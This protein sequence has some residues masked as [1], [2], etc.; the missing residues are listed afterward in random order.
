MENKSFLE[1]IKI[2][3]EE[4]RILKLQKE[5]KSGK[6]SKEDLTDEDYEKLITLYEKQNK[7]LKEKIDVQKEKIRKKLKDLKNN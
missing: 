1:N 2:D 3:K 5:Y 6:I 7:K 4:A